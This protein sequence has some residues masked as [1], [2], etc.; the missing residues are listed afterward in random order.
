M[1]EGG[2]V[3]DLGYCTACGRARGNADPFC[4]GCGAALGPLRAAVPASV[5]PPIEQSAP[6]VT[7]AAPPASTAWPARLVVRAARDA[8]ASVRLTEGTVPGSPARERPSILVSI[9]GLAPNAFAAAREQATSAGCRGYLSGPGISVD[10]SINSLYL[11]D[12]SDPRSDLAL[13]GIG[14]AWNVRRALDIAIE[15]VEKLAAPLKDDRVSIAIHVM[16]ADYWGLVKALEHAI[17]QPAGRGWAL[18]ACFAGA[19]AEGDHGR[20]T[21]SSIEVG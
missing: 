16:P 18:K 14:T 1:T 7:P 12:R 6:M 9:H 11:Q 4:G 2:M 5:A 19:R 21:G 15:I 3:I 13:R 8:V 10:A 17:G 20:P